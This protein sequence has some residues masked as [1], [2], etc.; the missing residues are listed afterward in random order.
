M[1]DHLV[2]IVRDL[3]R[4]AAQIEKALGVKFAPGG[5]HANK[6]TKNLLLHLGPATYLELL[7]IDE[8]N[9]SIHPPRWMGIDFLPGSQSGRMSRWAWSVKEGKVPV[10][11]SG[12]PLTVK[13]FEQ[14]SRI[15]PDG[16]Q[17]RW[18]LTDPGSSPLI[19]AEP[20]LIDWLGDPPPPHFLPDVGC[21]LIRLLVSGPRVSELAVLNSNEQIIEYR[22]TSVSRLEATIVNGSGTKVILV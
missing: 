21:R 1:I 22:N 4:S 13:P 10:G 6:G 8:D 14:S 2:Y 19:E 16:T 18:Q 9:T 15:K 12:A 7:A 20:F 11:T 17:L 5:K 3:S